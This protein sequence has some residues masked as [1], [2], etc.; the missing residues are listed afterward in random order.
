[1]GPTSTANI[2]YAR[3]CAERGYDGLVHIKSAGCTPEIDVMLF[4]SMMTPLVEMDP[5]STPRYACSKSKYL[6]S[7]VDHPVRRGHRGLPVQPGQAAGHR[8]GGDRGLRPAL[9]PPPRMAAPM[10]PIRWPLGSTRT[11]QFRVRSKAATT[12]LF[13]LTP[14]WNTTGQPL[15]AGGR[16]P[17]TALTSCGGTWYP[18]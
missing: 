10:A 18:I 1:M 2:W 7:H 14:P 11:G 13:L 16:G 8:G 15:R 3:E 6:L 5:T 9:H 4:L 17:V 12:P